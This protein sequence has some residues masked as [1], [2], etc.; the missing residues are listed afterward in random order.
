MQHNT[1]S[2]NP[3]RPL[4]LLVL[5][6]VLL[7]GPSAD[8]LAAEPTLAADNLNG[9]RWGPFCG[10]TSLYAAAKLTGRPDADL[11]AVLRSR[12]IGSD[13]GSSLAELV[14]AADQLGFNHAVAVKGL[15]AAQLRA[16]GTM[17]VLHVKSAPE[18]RDCDHYVLYLGD[19]DG[20]ALLM[21]APDAPRRVPY[22]KLG[23]YWSG[24]ALLLG[25]SRGISSVTRAAL[26]V[27][28]GIGMLF[29]VCLTSNRRANRPPA[30]EDEGD[31]AT[32]GAIRRKQFR[33]VGETGVMAALTLAIALPLYLKIT[34]PALAAGRA[35]IE[36]TYAYSFVPEVDAARVEVVLGSGATIL[37]A[38][39]PDDFAAGHIGGALNLPPD[40]GPEG[41]ARVLGD[42]P[43]DRPIIIY[44]AS[45]GCPYSD[46]V[47]GE[48][49][50]D[51]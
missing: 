9:R 39:A 7:V 36:A 10:V 21:D 46:F 3:R 34:S 51:G 50:G 30:G 8:A 26:F 42:A 29:A 49:W 32:S 19:R 38:R 15:D 1:S 47:A 44:C 48:L 22:S 11:Q 24:N 14:N 18:V 4:A 35:T 40:R 6:L 43:N 37:D 16:A 33:L 41:R 17:A 28:A 13:A 45:Q 12:Y 20:E 5:S 23:V 25:D 2:D 31:N 27:V